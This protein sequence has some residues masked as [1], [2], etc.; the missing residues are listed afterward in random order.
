M[1]YYIRRFQLLW[2]VVGIL[3]SC[4]Q[5]FAL[6]DYARSKG[7]VELSE[8]DPTILISPR[9]ATSDN[10]IGTPI[11]GYRKSTVVMLKQTA[12]ALKAAQAAFKKDGYCLVVYDAYRP[13]QAVDHFIRWI[14]NAVDCTNKA[15]YYPRVDKANMIAQGYISKRSGH[16]RGSRIDLTIIKEGQR[17]HPIVAKT[18]K[19]AD[20]YTLMFLD[21]GTVDMGSSFDLFDEASHTASTLVTVPVHK[22]RMYLKSVMEKYGFENY[23]KEWWHFSLNNEPYPADQESSSFNFP[24]E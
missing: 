1:N 20:G 24:L 5:C 6:S 21:D 16:S 23:D 17:V 3:T 14:D 2:L 10:F 9:Y 13:Q 12:Q 15:Q 7:F 11:D 8:V 19:L 18:R 22:M 4:G